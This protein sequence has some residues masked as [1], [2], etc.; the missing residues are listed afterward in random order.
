[1][2]GIG[3]EDTHMSKNKKTMCTCAICGKSFADRDV[4][5]GALIRDT[6]AD[7]I[8]LDHPGWSPDSDPFEI[9]SIADKIR[10]GRAY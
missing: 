5:A 9:R 1:M 8:R 4:V 6:I 7:E 10:E 3:G 2:F